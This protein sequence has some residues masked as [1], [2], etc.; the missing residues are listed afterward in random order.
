M[1]ATAE[2]DQVETGPD[3]EE[4]IDALDRLTDRMIE[5][6]ERLWGSTRKMI[7]EEYDAYLEKRVDAEFSILKPL[8]E[9]LKLLEELWEDPLVD[10]CTNT[11]IVCRSGRSI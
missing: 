1:K 11:S 3:L 10:L 7:E 8:A 9:R 4:M 5:G 6:G 2:R